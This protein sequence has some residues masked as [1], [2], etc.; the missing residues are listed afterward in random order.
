LKVTLIEFLQILLSLPAIALPKTAV[1]LQAGALKRWRAGSLLLWR[2]KEV[3]NYRGL[4]AH[5][6]ESKVCS[7]LR[8]LPKAQAT[9][10]HG[11]SKACVSNKSKACVS[12]KSKA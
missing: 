11:L 1:S 4:R 5:G 12:N 10:I 9:F 8:F 7:L 2:S 3:I 6:F